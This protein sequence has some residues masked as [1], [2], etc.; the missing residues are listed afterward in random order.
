[1]LIQG[2]YEFLLLMLFKI[3]GPSIGYRGHDKFNILIV[4]TYSTMKQLNI[5]LL[6]DFLTLDCID[7]ALNIYKACYFHLIYGMI[8]YSMLYMLISF[9]T[10]IGNDGRSKL[11]QIGR[12]CCTLHTPHIYDLFSLSLSLPPPFSSTNT[13]EQTLRCNFPSSFT[14]SY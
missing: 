6:Y 1:M 8:N 14:T 2:S 10:L 12:F 11:V 13:H 3:A 9:F 4:R 7:R 5:N